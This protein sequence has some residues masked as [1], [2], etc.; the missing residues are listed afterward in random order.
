MNQL[1][2]ERRKQLL[3]QATEEANATG[4][5]LHESQIS[6]ARD[7]L[8]FFE[9][10]ALFD[11]SAAALVITFVSSGRKNLAPVWGVKAG[12][13]LLLCA[14][15]AAMLRNWNYFQYVSAVRNADYYEAQ[16]RE[17][18][19]RADFYQINPPGI[20]LQDG[21]PFDAKKFKAEIEDSNDVIQS[22]VSDIRRQEQRAWKANIWAGNCA[23]IFTVAA[24]VLL[25]YVAVRSL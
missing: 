7:M 11:G 20:S 12:L 8:G 14:V 10:L 2:L 21:I 1:E 18:S 13:L 5:L 9:K 25:A 3:A 6:G 22:K 19:A 24:L 4:K 23:Q 17:Q 15:I 16:A